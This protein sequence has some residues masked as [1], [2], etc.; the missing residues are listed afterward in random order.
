MDIIFLQ[1]LTNALLKGFSTIKTMKPQNV[2]QIVLFVLI[3][4]L[5]HV[6]IALR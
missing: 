5:V 3:P 2:I 6:R 4:H 1:M